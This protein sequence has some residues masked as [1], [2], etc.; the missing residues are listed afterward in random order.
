M[1]WIRLNRK[2]IVRL[3]NRWTSRVFALL[4]FIAI[5]A[6]LSGLLKI[7]KSVSC[8]IFASIAILIIVWLISFLVCCIYV[9]LKRRIAILELNGGNHVYVQYGDIFSSDVVLNPQKR[10]NVV[11]AGNRCFDTL[12]DDDLIATNSLHG[13][14]MTRLYENG[15]YDSNSLNATIQENLRLQQIQYETISREN[16]RKGNLKM[17]PVGTVAEVTATPNCKY[18]FLG[19]TVMDKN[20]KT[21]VSEEDYLIALMRLL[22][23]CNDRAQ[24]FPVVIPLIGA[25]LSRTGKSDQEILSYLAT[26]IKMHKNHFHGDVHIVVRE[27]DKK[28]IAIT[29]L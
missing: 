8:R 15:L 18:F 19:L 23:F 22:E 12:I 16:K 10:R 26:F 17:Y 29:N 27:K 1:T 11:I 3:T 20:L 4:G 5:F 7:R 21:S 28:R 13:L 25:G 24:T 6:P 14:A 9:R 2:Y